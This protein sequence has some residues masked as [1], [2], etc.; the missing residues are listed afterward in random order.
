MPAE[1]I[2]TA[3]NVF[4]ELEALA[5]SCT[6]GVAKNVNRNETATGYK[7]GI[8]RLSGIQSTVTAV[9]HFFLMLLFVLQG[10]VR[11]LRPFFSQAAADTAIY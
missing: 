5:C 10:I 8:F 6:I 4:E 1:K 11:N 3:W 7:K 2:D 9:T